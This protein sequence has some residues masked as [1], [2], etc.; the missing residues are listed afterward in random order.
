M[1]PEPFNEHADS[2]EAEQPVAPPSEN[3]RKVWVTLTD[4]DGN[5]EKVEVDALEFARGKLQLPKLIRV[6]RHGKT[7]PVFALEDEQHGRIEIG[8][9]SKLGN[10]KHVREQVALTVGRFPWR[11]K[12]N[13]AWF[14]EIA[15]ALLA[16]QEL[17]E[18]DSTPEDVTHQWIGSLAR[19]LGEVVDLDDPEQR[20]RAVKGGIGGMTIFG[21]LDA[22]LYVHAPSLDSHVRSILKVPGV[23]QAQITGRLAAI[24]FKSVTVEAPRDQ[25][26]RKAKRRYWRSQPGYQ[27]G[28]SQ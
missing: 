14:D 24:G 18:S 4:E 28:E 26:G 12:R 13:G 2:R 7:D 6:I 27:A 22:C 8:A 19:N 25:D 1:S 23:T 3:E 20:A 21:A 9:I 11:N 17:E 16:I 5:K 10:P 15:E